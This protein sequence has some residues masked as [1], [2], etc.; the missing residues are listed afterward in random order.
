MDETNLKEQ[1][2]SCKEDISTHS[3]RPDRSKWYTLLATICLAGTQFTCT[4]AHSVTDV[5]QKTND[6]SC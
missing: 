4:V 3:V 2:I 6:P 5:I 1:G